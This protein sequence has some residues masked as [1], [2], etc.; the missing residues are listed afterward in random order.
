[1][2]QQ[3]LQLTD[4]AYTVPFNETINYFVGENFGCNSGVVSITGTYDDD[5][6]SRVFRR[7]DATL[8]A[9]RRFLYMNTHIKIMVVT[10][11][12]LRK[13]TKNWRSNCVALQSNTYELPLRPR[14]TV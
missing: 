13:H 7:R 9:R 14:D 3:G 5:S 10:W 8:K 1:M 6:L 2:I 11:K 4:I 12:L